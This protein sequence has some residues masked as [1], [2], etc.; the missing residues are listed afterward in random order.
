MSLLQR[1]EK[2][3]KG[4]LTRVERVK[5]LIAS[6]HFD[7]AEDDRLWL[8]SFTKDKTGLDICS[9]DM[10]SGDNSLGVDP[11]H[12]VIGT[13]YLLEGDNLSFAKHG[14]YDY[15]ISNYF[16]AFPAPLKAL[17]EWHRA[18]KLGGIVAFICCNSESYSDTM[19]PLTN[20]KRQSCQTKDTINFYLNRAGFADVQIDKHEKMLRCYAK[21]P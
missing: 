14:E 20:K 19:G 4:L 12:G 5:R 2:R 1:L 21:K 17:N 7:A 8:E 15:I 6:G 18:L 9:G 11:D 13:D 10:L 16:D 3:E